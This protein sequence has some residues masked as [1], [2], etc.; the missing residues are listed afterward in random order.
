MLIYLKFQKGVV[1]SPIQLVSYKIV[2]KSYFNLANFAVSQQCVRILFYLL[3]G[4]LKTWER[5]PAMELS[6]DLAFNFSPFS[7]HSL[8]FLIL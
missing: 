6:F 7:S 5:K 4:I 1:S 2:E 3:R 8:I